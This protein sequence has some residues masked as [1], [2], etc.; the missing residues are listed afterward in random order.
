MMELL[1]ILM[2][3]YLNT[4]WFLFSIPRLITCSHCFKYTVQY[5]MLVSHYCDCICSMSSTHNVHMYPDHT[6]VGWTYKPWCMISRHYNIHHG[7]ITII[8]ILSSS[9]VY[10]I[11]QVRSGGQLGWL[12]LTT[13]LY[14]ATG[15]YYNQI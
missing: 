15:E 8:I 7:E 10:L 6:G 1:N 13:Q 9:H 11:T 2:T 12:I 4:K 3:G 5:F 14:Q